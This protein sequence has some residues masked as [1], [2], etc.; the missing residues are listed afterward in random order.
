MGYLA[1]LDE[2]TRADGTEI[3]WSAPERVHP[4]TVLALI[5]RIVD[6]ADEMVERGD[7]E[8]TERDDVA[9]SIAYR[10]W[11]RA[12]I[13]QRALHSMFHLDET[14]GETDA[15]SRVPDVMER[16]RAH[17][18]TR[19]TNSGRT[20]HL[21]TVHGRAY[22]QGA[23]TVHPH[24]SHSMSAP[25]ASAML[26]ET[27]RTITGRDA[28]DVYR[29]TQ[30]LFGHDVPELLGALDVNYQEFGAWDDVRAR[31]PMRG[32]STRYR[33]PGARARATENVL[34]GECIAPADIGIERDD[35]PALIE[36]DALGRVVTKVHGRTRTRTVPAS[37]VWCGH[38]LIER[39]D[40]YRE[41]RAQRARTLDESLVIRAGD[42]VAHVLASVASA[43]SPGDAYRARWSVERAPDAPELA[44]TLTVSASG[45]Y[46]VRGIAP[47]VKARTLDAL[48]RG[49]AR[50]IAEQQ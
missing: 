46:S 44:G 9:S 2:W 10:I 39:G 25:R 37:H 4:L 1:S 29:A 26:D 17:T 21:V 23:T 6:T 11:H 43:V 35:V 14:T 36:R 18:R 22:V 7:I 41:Q 40:T 31:A 13:E 12:S 50:A 20:E 28:L 24:S 16:V 3:P 19:R 38:R 48:E 15:P 42:D 49:I 45:L 30:V 47:R 34:P 27:G 8:R 32:V 5:A 33:L